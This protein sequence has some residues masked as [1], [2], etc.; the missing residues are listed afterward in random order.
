MEAYLLSHVERRYYEQVWEYRRQM[1]EAGSSFDGCSS[2]D[3][4]EDM[5]KWDLNCRLFESWDTVPPGYSLG[6]EYLYLADDRVVGMVNIRPEALS[7]RYLKHYGGHIGYSVI[8]SRRR[9][10]IGTRMLKDALSL[11]RDEFGLDKVL[12]TCLKD[13][14]ESRGV[15]I[16]NGGEYEGDIFYP[17][18]EEYLERYWI[19]L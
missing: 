3:Q 4:Y 17:P 13:N 7:H 5:E 18:V 11:C 12:L 2:L 14:G 6:F 9:Q 10:G 1:L 15:I 16:R 8:P 19:S